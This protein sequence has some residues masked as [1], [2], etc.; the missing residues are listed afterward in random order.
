MGG[1]LTEHAGWGWVFF[2]NV[3]FGIA[4]T[5]VA[6]LVIRESKDPSAVRRIDLPGLLS[7]GAG[8][9]CLGFALIEGNTYGWS[10][11]VIVG[12]LA[13]AA[14]LFMVFVYVEL[15]LPH[16]LVDLRLFVNPTF[17]GA[18]IV[19]LLLSLASECS[20]G[21]ARQAEADVRSFARRPAR[22]GAQCSVCS[23]T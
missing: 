5:I 16:P 3:P 14:A 17:T 15:R 22:R 6:F 8:L 20:Q 7:S 11:D 1:L 9:F 19:S 18:L 23:S 13:A 21:P 4:G 10:S 12:L 2:I